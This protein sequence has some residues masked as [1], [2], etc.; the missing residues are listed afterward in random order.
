MG[1]L[2]IQ[3]KINQL[4]PQLRVEIE[5]Y[6]DFL[7]QKYQIIPSQSGTEQ[8]PYQTIT[9]WDAIQSFRANADFEVI[10]DVDD[11]FSQVRDRS[12][13]RPVDFLFLDDDLQN[14]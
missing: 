9:I 1:T 2:S 13:G 12:E 10:G 8:L 3:D 5:D 14:V 7:L 6:V 11:I 4:P